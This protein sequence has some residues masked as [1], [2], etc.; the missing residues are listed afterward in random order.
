MGYIT[1]KPPFGNICLELVPSASN[2][3]I[4]IGQIP[5]LGHILDP[6]KSIY[7]GI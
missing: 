2:K 3:Q 7:R 4:Q 1:I 6:Y 5:F